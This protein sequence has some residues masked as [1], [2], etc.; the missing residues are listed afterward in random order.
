MQKRRAD[1]RRHLGHIEC[2]SQRSEN[3]PQSLQK[4]LHKN[5]KKLSALMDA[6]ATYAI[7][8]IPAAAIAT[9]PTHFPLFRPANHKTGYSPK[10]V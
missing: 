9:K 2:F 1:K 10:G 7:K 5:G 3:H 8:I 6:N 4:L